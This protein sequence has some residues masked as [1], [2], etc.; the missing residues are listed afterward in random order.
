M[1]VI[2]VHF[3]RQL[4][5]FVFQILVS[6]IPQLFVVHMHPERCHPSSNLVN[7]TLMPHDFVVYVNDL[8]PKFAVQS[9][10]GRQSILDGPS[11]EQPTVN[12]SIS[13]RTDGYSRDLPLHGDADAAEKP[14]VIPDVTKPDCLCVDSPCSWSEASLCG[15]HDSCT[16]RRSLYVP[17]CFCMY[18]Y[19]CMYVYM[20][21][22][23]KYTRQI[24]CEWE[25]E[26]KR[27]RK[28]GREW[29]VK[30]NR[31]ETEMERR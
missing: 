2:P 7:A 16:S 30:G 4:F 19:I 23:G 14:V 20:Y 22:Y 25:R 10:N 31:D 29:E 3:H 5:Q 21:K 8:P 27:G 18:R 13:H 26:R 11:G 15:L 28:R 12:T 9:S 6:Q 17:L 1:E 24:S